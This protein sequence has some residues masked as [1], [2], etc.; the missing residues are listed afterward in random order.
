MR[1]RRDPILLR[2]GL[3][4]SFKRRNHLSFSLPL[5]HVLGSEV[6]YACYLSQCTICR[7][8][9]FRFYVI[10]DLKFQ[11]QYFIWRISHQHFT[12]FKVEHLKKF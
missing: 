10:H 5:F 11:W 2:A 8:G 6:E 1:D 3:Q 4:E 12:L 9:S 7:I